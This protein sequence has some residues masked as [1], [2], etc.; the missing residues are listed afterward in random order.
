MGSVLVLCK[1]NFRAL[2]RVK[3]AEIVERKFIRINL[4]RMNLRSLRSTI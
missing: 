3:A 4:I 2:G 1:V